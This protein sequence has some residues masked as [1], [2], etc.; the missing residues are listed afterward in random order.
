M[1]KSILRFKKSWKKPGFYGILFVAA[2]IFLLSGCSSYQYIAITGNAH[3]NRS[4]NFVVQN[5]TVKIIYSFKG[6]NFPV[7]VEVYNKLNKPLY[8]DWTN[9]ALIIDGKTV[10]FWQDIAH[11]SGSSQGYTIKGQYGIYYSVG[12][13]SGTIYK[14][15][16]V[17]FVAPESYVKAT[18]FH[19][20]TRFFNTDHNIS[21]KKVNFSSANGLDRGKKY[22]FSRENT[23]LEFR[24]YLTLSTDKNFATEIHVSNTFWVNGITQTFAN[25]ASLEYSDMPKNYIFDNTGGGNAISLIFGIGILVGIIALAK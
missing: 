4:Q 16:K 14:D 1:K 7:T 22:T 9:S 2:T 8:V 20:R 21:E 18:R 3:Q 25:P 10:S 24:S 11:L 17:S 6:N 5:D 19:L 13:L 12:D 23:P 15:E